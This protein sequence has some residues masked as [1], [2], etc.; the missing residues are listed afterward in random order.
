VNRPSA[1]G[2]DLNRSVAVPGFVQLRHNITMSRIRSYLPSGVD[3]DGSREHRL[4]K[5]FE[6]RG[7]VGGRRPG[8]GVVWS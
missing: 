1:K 6:A 3:V 7:A 5:E 2:I 4:G 8:G